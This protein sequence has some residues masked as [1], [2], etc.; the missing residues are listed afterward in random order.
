[1]KTKANFGT[2]SIAPTM[3]MK[4][5]QLSDFEAEGHDLIENEP[6]TH[7]FAA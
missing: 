4:T 7:Y 5:N 1:M 6:I 3:L 2:M